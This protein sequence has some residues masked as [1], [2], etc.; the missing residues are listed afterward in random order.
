MYYKIKEVYNGEYRL[1]LHYWQDITVLHFN[2]LALIEIVCLPK[3][4]NA[5]NGFLN[6]WPE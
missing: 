6:T 2:E 1:K 5:M 3:A 4:V